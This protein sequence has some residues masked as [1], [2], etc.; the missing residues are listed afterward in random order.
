MIQGISV[1]LADNDAPAVVVTPT[2]TM[3]VYEGVAGSVTTY[4]IV[5]TQ[6]P[7]GG[8]V[9]LNVSPTELSETELAAGSQPLAFLVGGSVLP[10][11]VLTFTA[12]NWF[13][14][15]TVTVFAPD[16]S[17]PQ[18]NQKQVS[19]PFTAG[20]GQTTFNLGVTPLRLESVRINGTKIR[21]SQA[22]VIGSNVQITAPIATGAIVEVTYLLQDGALT[23]QPLRHSI[24][25][26]SAANYHGVN[27]PGVVVEK[28]DNDAA[29]VIITPSGDDTVVFEGGA[30]DTYTVGLSRAPGAGETVTVTLSLACRTGG[31][32][33]A[34]Q[35]TRGRVRAGS[36]T[37]GGVR[38]GRGVRPV[39]PTRAGV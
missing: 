2:G 13:I 17:A 18:G 16:D 26:A 30:T 29:G 6:A 20:A 8:S 36:W 22:S 21:T 5:L 24:S 1:D 10:A 28:V 3:R 32:V 35:R 9:F 31:G 34:G 19:T 39:G 12:A 25:E 7:V 38:I 27:I 33:R 14:P 4:T 23:F 15:Q 37:G 11:L